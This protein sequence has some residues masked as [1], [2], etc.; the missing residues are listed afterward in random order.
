MTWSSE[1]NPLIQ[2]A[3]NF[4][5][6]TP[7]ISDYLA[8]SLFLSSSQDCQSTIDGTFVQVAAGSTSVVVRPE[9]VAQVAFICIIR[10][11]TAQPPEALPSSTSIAA[12]CQDGVLNGLESDVDCGAPLD[13][14]LCI[15]EFFLLPNPTALVHNAENF[16]IFSETAGSD[17]LVRLSK[18]QTCQDSFYPGSSSIVVWE[19][20]SSNITVWP[21]AQEQ[22]V[23]I[24]LSKD[25]LS[26]NQ[27]QSIGNTQVLASCTDGVQNG[28]E[29]GTDCA[30]SCPVCLPFSFTDMQGMPYSFYNP[31]V[32]RGQNF[33]T[34]LNVGGYDSL[35]VVGLF[36][37]IQ[38]TERLPLEGQDGFTLAS[39]VTFIVPLDTANT[40]FLCF[41]NTGPSGNFIAVQGQVRVVASCLD[42]QLLFPL[43]QPS[44]HFLLCFTLCSARYPLCTLMRLHPHLS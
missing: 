21:R 6:L 38:C 2:N 40:A 43:L 42:G 8:A 15:P 22:T 39:S 5:T 37:D 13:C 30:G 11:A 28:D 41:S 31:L 20:G 1:I 25:G 4:I 18:S 9:S 3:D 23:Y 33:V 17:Q 35:S 29:A 44:A 26:G 16:I 36:L 10:P 32:H 34:L 19:T 7:A 12:T 24:C 14:L 27:W